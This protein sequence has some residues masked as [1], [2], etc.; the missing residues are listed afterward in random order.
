[1]AE[2]RKKIETGLPHEWRE[3]FPLYLLSAREADRMNVIRRE[4]RERYGLP[5]VDATIDDGARSLVR[6]GVLQAI[7]GCPPELK[8][9]G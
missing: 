8:G 9:W 6:A 7:E 5:V 1:M 4:L 2:R 3:R